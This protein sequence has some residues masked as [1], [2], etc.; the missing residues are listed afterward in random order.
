MYL[1]ICW[2]M[3]AVVPAVQSVLDFFSFWSKRRTVAAA[4]SRLRPV[5]YPSVGVVVVGR[6][7]RR[8]SSVIQSRRTYRRYWSIC[9]IRTASVH[10]HRSCKGLQLALLINFVLVMK[11]YTN[12]SPWWNVCFK[13]LAGASDS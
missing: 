5:V 6:R 12:P 11:S 9:P 3:I 4:I 7:R 1:F 10:I 8:S 13:A 2:L